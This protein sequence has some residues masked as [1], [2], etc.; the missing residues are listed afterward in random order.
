MKSVLS[1][2]K[3]YDL[4]FKHFSYK[5]I[6]KQILG[7]AKKLGEPFTK[8]SNRGPK[9][10]ISPVEYV[11][12]IAFEIITGNSPYRDMEL[13]SELYVDEHI[14]H[15]TFGKNF[16]RIPLDYFIML[17]NEIARYLENLL[18]TAFCYIADSTGLVTNTYED[19]EYQGKDVRRR[20]DYKAHSFVGY[21]P[22]KQIVYVKNALG[23]DKHISDSKGACMMLDDY[24]LGWAYF[25]ADSNY[26]FEGLHKKLAE[27]GLSPLVKP[28]KT[29]LSKAKTTIKH[30]NL[31]IGR[32]YKE[33][34]HIIE[35]VFGGL[36]NKGLLSTKLRRED[37]IYKYAVVIHIRQNMQQLMGLQVENLL[38]VWIYSTNSVV[39]VDPK[40]QKWKANHLNH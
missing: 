25:S 28:R 34:R 11:S 5:A 32:L 39:P 6:Y 13:G 10:K 40:Y 14:D 9:F 35:A 24:N 16:I 17:L 37:N 3:K 8:K 7:F 36:E 31:F 26:D 27:K 29:K 38:V 4:V 15:S 30:R 22:D 2:W 12:Y 1:Y 20:K 19:T 33:L 23:S 21:Y 18:G